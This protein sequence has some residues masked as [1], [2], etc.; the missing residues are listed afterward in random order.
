MPK[1]PGQVWAEECALAQPWESTSLN[2]GDFPCYIKPRSPRPPVEGEFPAEW[3]W[4]V[5]VAY[6]HAGIIQ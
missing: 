2:V 6:R 5:R 3:V 4:R 1:L